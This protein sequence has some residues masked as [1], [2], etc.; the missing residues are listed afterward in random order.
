[1]SLAEKIRVAATYFSLETE[2]VSFGWI[3]GLMSLFS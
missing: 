2:D 1:M 3:S